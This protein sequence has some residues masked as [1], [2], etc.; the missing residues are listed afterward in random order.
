MESKEYNTD[1]PVTEE[2]NLAILLLL[3]KSQFK[4]PVWAFKS[5]R[6]ILARFQLIASFQTLVTKLQ[7]LVGYK[8]QK[9]DCCINL[10]MGF[11]GRY[12]DLQ[13]CRCEEPRFYYPRQRACLNPNARVRQD[14]LQLKPRKTFTD[15]P[16]TPRLLLQYASPKRATEVNTYAYT[17]YGTN[18]AENETIL[19]SN[20][21][22]LTDFWSGRLCE[23]LYNKQWFP[24]QSRRDL[25]FLLTF[26]GLNINKSKKGH[27]HK[28]FICMSDVWVIHSQ[29]YS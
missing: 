23:N 14:R 24:D 29:G 21:E 28:E 5:L 22:A 16:I 6:N 4:I 11:T 15:F 7:H 25:A 17:K 26:D 10:C 18:A 1:L 19:Y 20:R 2:L 9:I 8:A 12:K 13:E 27:A 3:W